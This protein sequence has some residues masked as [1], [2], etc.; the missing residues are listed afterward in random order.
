MCY[1]QEAGLGV[2]A[3][4]S[5]MNV[6]GDSPPSILARD[7]YPHFTDEDTDSQ[8]GRGIVPKSCS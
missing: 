8:R 6:C 4:P 2:G 7:V 1:Q 3:D 5:P